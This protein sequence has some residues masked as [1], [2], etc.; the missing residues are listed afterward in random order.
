M[1]ALRRWRTP[2]FSGDGDFVANSQPDVTHPNFSQRQ[3]CQRK[4]PALDFLKVRLEDTACQIRD[5]AIARTIQI[6]D[7]K[8]EL[9]VEL[10]LPGHFD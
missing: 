3:R 8:F 5:S 7:L 9:L 4:L 2:E 1:P 6:G 10:K